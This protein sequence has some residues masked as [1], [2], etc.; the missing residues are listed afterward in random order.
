MSANHCP[1]IAA[2]NPSVRRA[3]VLA[4]GGMRVAYQAG[5]V[6]AL[7]DEGL[8]FSHADG[9]SGGTINL[10]ALLS[11]VPPDE[12]C[13]RWRALPVKQFAALRP[14]P[15][16]LHVANMSALG[17]A[18]GLTEHVYPALGIDINR[19]RAA[20]GIDGSFNACCFDDKT[21]VPIPHPQ[22]DLP[23]LV[24]AASLPIFMPAVKADGKTWTDA[25]WIKDANLLSCVERG[26]R[27]LWLVWCIGNTPVYRDGAFN[28]Y[29]HMIEMSAGGALNRELETI[30]DINRRIACGECVFGHD[31]PISVHVIKPEVPL[32]LDP[33]FYRGRIDAA[34]LID[35]GYRDARRTLRISTPSP[36]NPSAA[37]MREPGVGLSFRETMAGGFR[38][39]ATDPGAVESDSDGT[40][41]TMNATIHIDD[42][43]AFIA[44]PRHLGGLTGHIDFAPFGLAMPSES[45]VFGLFTPCDDPELTYMIYEIGFRHAGQP[46]YLAGKKHVRIGSP[47]RMWGETT[48]LYTTLHRGG[49][50]TGPVV[51][52]GVLHLGV[53]Q[54]GRLMQT[55]Y[56]TNAPDSRQAAHAISRFFRFFVSELWRIYIRRSPT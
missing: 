34:T 1:P 40:P 29:V 56:A 19:V 52:A 17:S 25:V 12:L 6:K 5:A 53:P 43:A 37:V 33:D 13:A 39:G 45:G 27:E 35:M 8:R 31:Q 30:A 44:D 10:A 48:T 23:R 16:Y 49:D 18:A 41:L 4:G 38:L 20:A 42:M 24:A 32:P 11:G 26:A 51:G 21:V 28:Q 7:I 2:D 55:V 47:F 22:L 15:E 3:L 50:A 9:A 54:L 46:Y 36:L 14:A